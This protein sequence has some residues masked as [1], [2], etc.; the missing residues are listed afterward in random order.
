MKQRLGE[1]ASVC[2]AKGDLLSQFITHS[3][4]QSYAQL[5]AAACVCVM[6]NM[7]NHCGVCGLSE[8]AAKIDEVF[9]RDVIMNFIIAGRDTTAVAMTWA[10]HLIATHPEVEAKVRA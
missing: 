6:L 3:R 2:D 5:Q 9:L 4:T 1:A 10:V 8:Y 7:C